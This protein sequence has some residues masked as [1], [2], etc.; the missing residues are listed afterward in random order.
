[1]KNWKTVK[2]GSLLTESKIVSENPNT[3][4]RIS[5]RL[6]VQGVE[7]RPLAKEK[8]EPLNTIPERQGNSFMVSKICIK[9]LLVLFLKN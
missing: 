8:K 2:L 7:K 5:V 9:V 1:M 4:K 3:D 6:N